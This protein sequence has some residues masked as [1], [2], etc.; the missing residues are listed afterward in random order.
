MAKILRPRE[1]FST[2]NE[3]VNKLLRSED[4]ATE[5]CTYETR[6]F[7]LAKNNN[8]LSLNTDDIMSFN[9]SETSLF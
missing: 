9:I 8:G 1:E 4:N 3:I 5:G 7:S 2:F 6:F